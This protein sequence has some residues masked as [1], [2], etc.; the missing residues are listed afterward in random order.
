MRLARENLK[1]DTDIQAVCVIV[2]DHREQAR[3]HRFGGWLRDLWVRAT[4]VG[5]SSR[6]PQG[7]HVHPGGTRHR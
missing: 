7:R 2:D 6:K 3:S 1:G 4:T 5:A